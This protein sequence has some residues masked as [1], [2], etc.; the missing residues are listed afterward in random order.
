MSSPSQIKVPI[1]IK[2]KDKHVDLMENNIPLYGYQIK[3]IE[4]ESIHRTQEEWLSSKSG[5]SIPLRPEQMEKILL[6]KDQV[7]QL[8]SPDR[9]PEELILKRRG[10]GFSKHAFERAL[11]RI[12]RLSE[13]ELNDL[14]SNY[15]YSIDPETLE[16]IA[17]S[18][19]NSK[20][21]YEKAEWKAFPYL[22]FKFLSKYDDRDIEIVVNFKLGILIVT[23]IVVKETGFFVREV[24]SFTDKG[25]LIKKP[26]S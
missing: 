22:N 4:K 13:E 3:I 18:L 8:L 26:S 7:I 11:T 2:V 6:V 20:T 25:E 10:F 16:K 9:N 24:Y 21:V 12:E 15:S 19:I 23:L 5:V 14:G 17:E 1:K